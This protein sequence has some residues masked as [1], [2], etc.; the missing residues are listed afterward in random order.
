M[1]LKAI[2]LH[3]GSNSNGNFRKFTEITEDSRPRI[4][5]ISLDRGHNIHYN[6]VGDNMHIQMTDKTTAKI[7]GIK[8]F[9]PSHTFQ[10]GQCFRWEQNPDGSFEGVAMGKAVRIA[11]KDD[12]ILIQNTDEKDVKDLWTK[13]LDLDRDYGQIKEMYKKDPYVSRAMEFGGGIRIL[14]QDMFECLVSFIIS[15]QNQIPRIKK[16]VSLLCE[17]YGKKI[18]LWDKAMY[19]FPSAKELYGIEAGDLDFLRAGYRAP[20]IADAVNSVA[21][22]HVCLEDI[23]QMPYPD[24]KRQI[25]TLRG[26]GPK[27]ADCILLFGAGKSEAFPV[28]VWVQR[29]MRSLYLGENATNREIEVRARELFGSYA[30]FAQQYLFYYAREKGGFDRKD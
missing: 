13:Y 1:F 20:Y 5:G 7:S 16:I 3:I 4:Q 11:K 21:K 15:A 30:G 14:N 25:M 26:V 23:R 17:K 22:G 29:T 9:D 6:I 12:S 2:I 24:A 18:T 8:D 28:D 10:C 19:T 27:V